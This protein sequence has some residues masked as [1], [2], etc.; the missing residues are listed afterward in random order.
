MQSRNHKIRLD[1]LLPHYSTLK[2][3]VHSHGVAK[4]YSFKLNEGIN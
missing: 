3:L 4:D 1:E 2:T